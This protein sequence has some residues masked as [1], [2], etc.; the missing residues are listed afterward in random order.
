MRHRC[1][2]RCANY[3]FHAYILTQRIHIGSST[4]LAR[5]KWILIKHYSIE[6]VT[7]IK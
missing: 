7:I 4:T 1:G 3:S 2:N 6:N 5:I